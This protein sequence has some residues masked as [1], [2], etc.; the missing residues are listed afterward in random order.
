LASNE[1]LDAISPK[2]LRSVLART[3]NLVRHD[4]PKKTIE[5]DFKILQNAVSSDEEFAKLYGITTLDDPSSINAT[6]PFSLTGVAAELGYSYWHNANV[7]INKVE[8]EKGFNIKK[9]DNKYHIA[10]RVGDKMQTHKYSH[11]CIDLLR[12]VKEGESY[13]LD[14]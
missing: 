7:L 12:K 6:Y 8:S 14:F 9:S 11:S 4:I 2:L 3:Y 5:V 10:I 13:E 1:A